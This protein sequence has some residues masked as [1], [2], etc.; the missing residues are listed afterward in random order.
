MDAVNTHCPAA[1]ISYANHDCIKD[2]FPL[3]YREMV[4][5]AGQ[6]AAKYRLSIITY[7]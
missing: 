3:S 5:H 4:G 6:K 2:R 7:Y 1:F